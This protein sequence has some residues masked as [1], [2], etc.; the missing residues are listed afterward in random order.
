[1]EELI[2]VEDTFLLS[3]RGLVLVPALP[4]P[5]S[6]KVQAWRAQV[7]IERPNGEVVTLEAVF[8]PEHFLLTGGGSRWHIPITLQSATKDLVPIG[9]VVRA[10]RETIDRLRGEVR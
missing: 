1:M 4:L 8:A 6:G 3:G 9:S 7:E 10:T 5:A 2:R